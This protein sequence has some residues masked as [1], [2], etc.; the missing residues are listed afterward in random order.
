MWWHLATVPF[1][2]Q[3]TVTAACATSAL[4]AAFQVTGANLRHRLPS[5][6]EITSSATQHM[7]LRSRVFPNADGL[8]DE[9]MARA[10]HS[11]GLEP[12]YIDPARTDALKSSIYAYVSN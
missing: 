10:I 4:W 8:T 1:Q 7:P 3:D 5:P 9:Q 2:E 11:V 6:V 12:Y